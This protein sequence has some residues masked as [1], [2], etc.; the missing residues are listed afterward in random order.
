MSDTSPQLEATR[1]ARAYLEQYQGPEKDTQPFYILQALVNLM[2]E[3]LDAGVPT[4]KVLFT[5][6]DITD[7][8]TA[9]GYTAGPE[10]KGESRW[11][12]TKWERVKT[13]LSELEE[14]LTEFAQE[15]NHPY[16]PTLEKKQSKGGP[17]NPSYYWIGSKSRPIDSAIRTYATPEGGIKYRAERRRPKK[18]SLGLYIGQRFGNIRRYIVLTLMLIIVLTGY[19]LAFVPILTPVVTG[20]ATPW[21]SSVGTFLVFTGLFYWLIG[22]L[23]LA[24][25]YKVTP[26]PPWSFAGDDD[27]PML[28]ESIR[29]EKLGKTVRRIDLVKY[30]SICPICGGRVVVGGGGLR[31]WG[32]LIGRC[33]NSPR[34]H[35][36]SFD[37]ITRIGTALGLILQPIG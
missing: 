21:L 33:S 37:H 9:I 16:L 20:R 26:L 24:S 5:P 32:R 27:E 22:P 31:F 19:L 35:V 18:R 12:T 3:Q 13:L 4:E 36:Y 10:E 11:I 34:E 23:L 1:C 30:T 8:V 7:V 14:G 28:L 6:K 17:N 29:K 2:E 15:N 25:I